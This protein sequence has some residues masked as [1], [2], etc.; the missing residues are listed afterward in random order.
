MLQPSVVCLSQ[1]ARVLCTVEGCL[2]VADFISVCLQRRMVC[3]LYQ[4]C[5]EVVM[6]SESPWHIVHC[7]LRPCFALHA[8]GWD[9][10]CFLM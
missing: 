8:F 5:G 3:C 6:V 4:L 7:G 9:W 10:F 1:L 2:M